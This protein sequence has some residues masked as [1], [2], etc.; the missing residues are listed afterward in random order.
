MLH[1]IHE[2][3]QMSYNYS[4]KCLLKDHDALIETMKRFISTYHKMINTAVDK[5]KVIKS[6]TALVIRS[7]DRCIYKFIQKHVDY[8]VYSKK[9]TRMNRIMQIEMSDKAKLILIS[10]ILKF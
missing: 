4:V 3:K 6:N 7:I 5:N 2:N 9:V 1:D 8:G 10:E